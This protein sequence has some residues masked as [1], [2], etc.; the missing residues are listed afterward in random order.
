MT[1]F[2]GIVEV[3]TRIPVE[4]EAEDHEAPGQVALRTAMEEGHFGELAD[5]RIVELHK[6]DR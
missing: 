5:G 6:V 2:T 4:F 3:V 1:W